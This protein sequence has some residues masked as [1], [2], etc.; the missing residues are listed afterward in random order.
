[1]ALLEAFVYDPLAEWTGSDSARKTVDAAVALRLLSAHVTETK[2]H[3]VCVYVH[4]L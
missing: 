2:S 4:V 1:M 3:W